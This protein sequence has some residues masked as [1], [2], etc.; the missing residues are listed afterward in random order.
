MEKKYKM[1]KPEFIIFT[2]K[3]GTLNLE[4]KKLNNILILI[5]SMGGIVIPVTGRTVG[6]I[7]EDLKNKKIR[8]PEI[9][10]G[11]NGANIYH[12]KSQ[13]F[14]IKRKLQHE[15]VLDII[16]NFIENGGN[17][18]YIRYTDGSSIFAANSPDVKKYYKKSKTAK[19]CDD[20]LRSIE[21]NEDITK[22][23]L[24][25]TKTKMEQSAEFAKGLDFWTDMDETKFPNKECGNYRLDIAQK[26][27]NKGEAVKAVTSQL[28]PTFGYICVGNGYND[29]SMFKEA[30]DNGMVA[31]IMGNSS[32]ELIREMREYAQK[33]KKGR[34]VIIP[35]NKDLAN[36]YMLQYAK[37]FQRHKKE[38]RKIPE[39]R[40]PNVQRVKIE[41][42]N[43][44]TNKQLTTRK[45]MR[46]R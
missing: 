30:I 8:L 33:S 36:K 4:D 7:T 21:E 37:L 17:P 26:N 46:E 44:V 43:V 29:I 16:A 40:L 23:T 31:A 14:L 19:I 18:N 38:A 1:K 12:T 11:D 6:D 15:K 45:N 42:K 34:V 24:A 13:N 9:I 35:H 28:K 5:K 20:I 10:V 25:G 2:D 41:H 3:D 22:I 32:P 27:I 39:E